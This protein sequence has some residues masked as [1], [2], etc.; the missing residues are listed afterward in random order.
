M[1]KEEIAKNIVELMEEMVKSVLESNAT[2]KET[3]KKETVKKETRGRKPSVKKE[4]PTKPVNYEELSAI[5]LFKLC[6]ERKL[7]VEPKKKAEYYIDLLEENDME[8]AED[9]ADEDNWEEEPE[10]KTVK[11]ETRGRKSKVVK[12][13]PEDEDDWE[14]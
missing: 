10:E 7:K 6:K 4:E 11:K 13:E 14:I 8:V 3:V 5:E 9:E 12:E 1:K 2:E